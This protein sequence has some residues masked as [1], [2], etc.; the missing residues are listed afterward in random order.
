VRLAGW[1]L[2]LAALIPAG[3]SSSTV[4]VDYD[5]KTDFS[6]VHTWAWGAPP[7][8]APRNPRLSPFTL[9]RARRAIED[10]LTRKGLALS[11]PEQADVT[12]TVQEILGR[13]IEAAPGYGGWGWGWGW[14]HPGG[15]YGWSGYSWDGPSYYQVEETML[16]IELRQGAAP[17]RLVWRGTVR[18]PLDEDLSPEDQEARIRA[19]IEE[20]LSRFPPEGR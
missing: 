13:R 11:P 5:P 19:M 1:S 20:V 17:G 3:C 4:A 15:G 9:E 6:Q 2:L 8:S 16:L 10:V 7:A 18:R 14:G 12:V